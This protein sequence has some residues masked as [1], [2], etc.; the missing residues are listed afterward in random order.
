MKTLKKI[1]N[2]IFL[3]NADGTGCACPY[4]EA[5]LES[6]FESQSDISALKQQPPVQITTKEQVTC[7]SRCALFEVKG[8]TVALHCSNAQYKVD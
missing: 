2:T 5:K 4:M 1:G 3:S 8:T 6:K 7:S